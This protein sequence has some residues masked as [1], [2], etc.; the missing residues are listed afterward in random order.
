[1][2][3][4]VKKTLIWTVFTHNCVSNTSNHMKLYFWNYIFFHIKR[5]E[6]VYITCEH[7]LFWF[8]LCT[9]TKF[10]FYSCNWIWNKLPITNWQVWNVQKTTLCF[11]FFFFFFFFSFIIIILITVKI[12]FI[13]ELMKNLKVFTCS[14]LK[15]LITED[16][17]WIQLLMLF[18]L[19]WIFLTVFYYLHHHQSRWDTGHWPL[20]YFMESFEWS[21]LPKIRHYNSCSFSLSSLFLAGTVCCSISLNSQDWSKC[22]IFSHENFSTMAMTYV[23]TQN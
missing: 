11:F 23:Q 19:Q 17:W 2:E 14:L 3:F 10:H 4:Y 1:M 21:L 20:K 18:L 8:M 12:Y 7:Y 9:F 15:T 6:H 22:K 5:H 16:T 13:A